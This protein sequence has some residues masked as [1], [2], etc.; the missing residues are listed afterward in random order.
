MTGG[1]GVGGARPDKRALKQC[2]RWAGVFF[3]VLQGSATSPLISAG[4]LAPNS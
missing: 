4:P 3:M 1:G 2:T